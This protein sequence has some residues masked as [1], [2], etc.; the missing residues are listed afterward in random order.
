MSPAVLYGFET[1]SLSLREE[2]NLRVLNDIF[3]S[4]RNDVTGHWRILHDKYLHDLRSTI[5][6]SG[7]NISRKTRWAVR[8]ARMVKCRDA[9]VVFGG[10]T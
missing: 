1:R 2:Q 8:V 7:V 9:Y 6:N 4:E 5:N 3:G 10:E